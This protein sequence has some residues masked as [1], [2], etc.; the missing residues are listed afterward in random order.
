[1]AMEQCEVV[2]FSSFISRKIL[3]FMEHGGDACSWNMVVSL[4][5]LHGL[6]LPSPIGWWWFREIC[7]GMDGGGDLFCHQAVKGNVG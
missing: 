7:E 6:S 3:G 1:M 5:E 2:G 4:S